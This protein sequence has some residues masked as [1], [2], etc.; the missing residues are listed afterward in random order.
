MR[1]A[2]ERSVN[3]FKPPNDEPELS[4]N[5]KSNHI[6]CRIFTEL[7]E[8]S[9]KL[10][11][12][13]STELRELWI[14]ISSGESIA[15]AELLECPELLFEHREYSQSTYPTKQRALAPSSSIR[16]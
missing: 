12:N 9:A 5:F 3:V 15:M 1:V 2:K 8:L 10:A 13:D 7:R 14:S 16:V 6:F 4:G 11:S